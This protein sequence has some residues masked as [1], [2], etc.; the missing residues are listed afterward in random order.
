MSSVISHEKC[1]RCGGVLS[2]EFD[3]RSFEEWKGCSRC[4]R[5]DGWHYIRDEEGNAV[6]DAQGQPQKEFDDLPGYGVAYLQFEKVGVCYPLTQANDEKLK[7][8]FYQELHNNDK[9]IKDKC[10]LT[11]WNDGIGEVEAEYGNVPETFDEM[12]SRYAK[13]TEDAE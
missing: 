10:Y 7:E 4:G 12:E 9:L 11:V 5:R 2:I 6:L 3:C 13:E 1:P 8:V